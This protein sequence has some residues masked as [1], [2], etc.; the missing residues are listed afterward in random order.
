VVD[1]LK[2]GEEIGDGRR[3]PFS[4]RLGDRTGIGIGG[5]ERDA[6]SEGLAIDDQDGPGVTGW[7]ADGTHDEPTPEER[8]GRIGHFDLVGIWVLEEGIKARLLSTAS[9]TT[10]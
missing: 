10:S 2:Q 7:M 6:Q 5:D 4:R 3:G 1:L 8:M 9:R